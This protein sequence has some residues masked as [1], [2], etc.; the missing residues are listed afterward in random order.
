MSPKTL[1]ERLEADGRDQLTPDEARAFAAEQT[2]KYLGMTPEEFVAAADADTLPD[3]PVVMHLALLL[4]VTLK[5][6]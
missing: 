2:Q 6:C 3:S 5:R 4:G 1:A